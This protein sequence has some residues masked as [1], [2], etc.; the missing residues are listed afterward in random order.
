MPAISKALRFGLD[1]QYEERESPRNKLKAELADL[2]ASIQLLIDNDIIDDIDN[3]AVEAKKEKV[4]KYLE[5]SRE[6]S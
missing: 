2:I 3:D 6:A 5:Y 1:D 4:K